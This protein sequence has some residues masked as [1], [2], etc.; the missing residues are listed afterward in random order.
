MARSGHRAI[1]MPP[2]PDVIEPSAPVAGAWDALR[3]AVQDAIAAADSDRTRSP[4][5]LY[6][7][8]P[9][10]SGKSTLARWL[11]ARLDTRNGVARLDADPGQG[12]LGP[13][14]TLGLQW[15]DPR[16]GTPHRWETCLGD[17]TPAACPM[18]F[19]A[20]LT[21]L[22]YRTP[23]R[24]SVWIIDACG[25]VTGELGRELQLHSLEAVGTTHLVRL[26]RPPARNGL[27]PA[28]KAQARHRS[29]HPLPIDPGVCRR[30]PAARRA[31]RLARFR[32]A[33]TGAIPQW[34]PYHGRLVRGRIPGR[35]S[36]TGRTI[37]LCDRAGWLLALGY[38][39]TVY[40]GPMGRG[41]P[42]LELLAP[43]IDLGAVATIHLGQAVIPP[44]ALE[45]PAPDDTP[46]FAGAR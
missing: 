39:L 5:S 41:G 4:P 1:P 32:G 15:T 24:P 19:M 23:V 44:E 10:D 17:I 7:V 43:A 13:P 14:T 40:H 28:L 37:G 20:A 34:I 12:A 18:D 27:A 26:G 21:A 2:E 30:S 35:G 42:S 9:T 31:Q 46:P 38:G 6:L 22:V 45:P 25:L 36:I 11:E 33:L 16:G 29:D 8:G 3:A